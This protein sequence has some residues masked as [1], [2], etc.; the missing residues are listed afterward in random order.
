MNQESES[1]TDKTY[2]ECRSD[3]K[4]FNVYYESINREVKIS[5]IYECRYDERLQTLKKLH[6]SLRNLHS[7]YTLGYSGDWKT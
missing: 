3:V 6:V 2:K 4:M 1:H 5:P 7:S